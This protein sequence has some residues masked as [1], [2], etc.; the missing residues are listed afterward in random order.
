MGLYADLS[1]ISDRGNILTQYSSSSMRI[2]DLTRMLYQEGSPLLEARLYWIGSWVCFLPTQ[3]PA[4]YLMS[5]VAE[6]T[7]DIDSMMSNSSD[8]SKD[9]QLAMLS[10]RD[11]LS[12]IQCGFR[13]GS[14]KAA[15][16][17]FLNTDCKSPWNLT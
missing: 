17:S 7:A 10:S 13:C 8:D 14:G 4:L 15:P 12:R 11:V 5:D 9:P 16:C 1:L 2:A 3:V 6:H